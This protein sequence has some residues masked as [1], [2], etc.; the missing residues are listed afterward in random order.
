MTRKIIALTCL[1][2]TSQ[3]YSSANYVMIVNGDLKAM[4][5][6][7]GFL[8]NSWEPYQVDGFVLGT[9]TIS[10]ADFAE[11]SYVADKTKIWKVDGHLGTKT[12][13]MCRMYSLST[14]KGMRL[15]FYVGEDNA[16]RYIVFDDRE[17]YLQFR[18]K[19]Q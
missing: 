7:K 17:D 9:E 14:D 15:Q 2:L 11:I 5:Y 1:F 18:C 16:R 4:L 19:K 8:T 6:K 3:V 12:N 13:R 10:F